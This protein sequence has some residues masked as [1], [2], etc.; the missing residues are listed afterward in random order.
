MATDTNRL[1]PDGLAL[2][3]PDAQ[4]PGWRPSRPRLPDRP[5]GLRAEPDGLRGAASTQDGLSARRGRAGAGAAAGAG[6]LAADRASRRGA[7][8]ADFVQLHYA[9]E[10]LRCEDRPVVLQFVSSGPGEGTSTVAAGFAAVA[11]SERPG[12]V[13]VVSCGGTDADAART[14]TF[15]NAGAE[16][17]GMASLIEADAAGRQAEAAI[18]CDAS[19]E[20]LLR[21]R[22]G[23]S[24]HPLMEIGAAALRRLLNGLGERYATV[25]LDCAP[26]TS[27][28]S[29][30][31]SRHCDGTVLVVRAETARVAAVDQ[32]RI[33]VERAG[34]HVVGVVLNRRRRPLPPWLERLL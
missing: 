10:A 3:A 6:V 16:P 22:L 26:A 4:E 28:D 8:S 20:G 7:L 31:L 14:G 29:A 15:G 12:A 32:A 34:G 25:V 11:A 30:A 27:P 23:V 33:A 13:L 24:A 2:D 17:A 1:R 21:A 18:W 19:C 5:A 9:I